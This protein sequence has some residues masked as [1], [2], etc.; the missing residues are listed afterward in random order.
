[1]NML[2]E[3]QSSRQ[4]VDGHRRRWFSSSEMDLIVW[5]GEG[6]SVAAFELY[7]DKNRAEHVLLWRADHGSGL[8]PAQVVGVR[9]LH[10]R[11]AHRPPGRPL[12]AARRAAESRYS[13]SVVCDRYE[14]L[15]DSLL[16]RPAHDPA[17]AS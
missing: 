13:F 12:R 4:L 1:M 11:G 6:G 15:Y 14:A 9:P 17:T 3:W 10:R 8:V 16:G 5:Y 7:Y 2:V